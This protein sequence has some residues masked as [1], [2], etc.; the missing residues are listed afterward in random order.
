MG[1]R[2]EGRQQ[3]GAAI[4]ADHV[5]PLAGEPA[6]VEV[7]EERLPFGG[8]FA[9]RQAEVDDLLLAVGAQPQ[10]HQHRPLERA[11][12]G[13]AGKHHAIEHQRFVAVL[14]RPAMEGG[15]G[16]IERLGDLAH[17]R[18]ADLAAEQGQ[19]RLAHLAGG[20]P[21][22]EAGQ[23]HPV[24]LPRAARIGADDLGRAVASGPRNLQLDVA[25]LGQKMPPIGPVAA[26]GDVLGRKPLEMALDRCCHLRLENLLQSLPAE[27]AV[28]LAPLQTV[29]LHRLHDLKGHR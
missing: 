13:L 25:E 6:A 21:K 11:G 27:R 28:T 10:G 22:H 5:E 7:G 1:D 17:R 23:D 3:A 18:R 2:G 12:A 4:D 19:Q 26:V 24:D 15:H 9:R 20:Q 16:G 8:A 29:R 14:Q